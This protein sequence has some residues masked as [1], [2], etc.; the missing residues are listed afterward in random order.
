M[1]FK[2]L[3][4]ILIVCGCKEEIKRPAPVV[5]NKTD[6]LSYK[7]VNKFA[8]DPLAFTQG[9]VYY[10]NK[11][12]EGTGKN[13]STWISELDPTTFDY[14]KKIVLPKKYFGEGITIMDG[15]IYQL[16]YKSKIGF[17]YNAETYKKEDQFDY[18]HIFKEGWGLT[19]DGTHLIA[20]DGS[21]TLYFLDPIDYHLHHKIVI[22]RRGGVVTRVNELEYVEG[23]IYA[24]I[25][26][27]NKIIKINPVSGNVNGE[28]DLSDLHR[29][30]KKQSS[31]MDVMN[32]IA[33]NHLKKTFIITG[34]YWPSYYEIEIKE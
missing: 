2:L 28:I 15:K 26:Q 8:H 19:N 4:I 9:L 27:S 12:I 25:W 10:Q 24:N 16:T 32:G 5:L 22:K 29:V 34:K 18:G 23:F 3:F 1:K 17:I 30:L 33:Y 6:F 7:V 13:G 11:I 14:Q 31:K 21:N 20:S